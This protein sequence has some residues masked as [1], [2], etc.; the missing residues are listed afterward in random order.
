M[1]S[2]RTRVYTHMAALCLILPNMS[3][4]ERIHSDTNFEQ[5]LAQNSF[6]V[7]KLGEANRKHELE[8]IRIELTHKFLTQTKAVDEAISRFSAIKLSDQS[9]QVKSETLANFINQVYGFPSAKATKKNNLFRLW[10]QFNSASSRSSI[11]I[12]RSD[13]CVQGDDSNFK[14]FIAPL[15]AE[16]R[17]LLSGHPSSKQVLQMLDQVKFQAAGSKTFFG[18][19]ADYVNKKPRICINPEEATPLLVP[20]LVHELTHVQSSKLRNLNQQF[21]NAAGQWQVFHIQKD[22]AEAD[23]Y[24]FEDKIKK[25]YLTSLET[26]NLL[27][28]LREKNLGGFDEVFA[29][30]SGMQKENPYTFQENIARRNHSLKLVKLISLSRKSDSL[31]KKMEG[32]R[33]NYDI[34]RFLDE[35]RAYLREYFA[36]VYMSKK[37]PEVFCKIWVPSFAQKRPVRFF[38]AYLE[39]ES[40]LLSGK[41]SSWLANLYTFKTKSYIASSLYEDE[42][43]KELK[44]EVLASAQKIISSQLKQEKLQSD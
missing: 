1:Q 26:D 24:D 37:H 23:L 40:R 32:A 29:E 44:K 9:L 30:L 27:P 6:L 17:R 19:T 34:E 38:E 7:E 31:L 3:N 21:S 2:K 16:M 11:A 15:K 41:F 5:C 28:K 8:R 42:N 20:K 25:Q 35:H 18:A 10:L 12:D 39:L 43:K 13:R 22:Q 36:A 33:T 14:A 4:A